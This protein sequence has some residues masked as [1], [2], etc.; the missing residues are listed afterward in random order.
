[1]GTDITYGVLEQYDEI[2]KV[3]RF[4]NC[5]LSYLGAFKQSYTNL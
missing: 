3:E 4:E 1:M 5:K 2:K